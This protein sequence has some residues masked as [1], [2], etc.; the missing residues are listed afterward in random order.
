MILKHYSMKNSTLLKL[1]LAVFGLVI[2]STSSAQTEGS[3]F[4]STGRGVATPF[5]T[6]Y[7]ALGINPSNLDWAPMYEGKSVTF[8]F[9]EVSTSLY[10]EAL[11]KEDLR[12][13][14]TQADFNEL[15]PEEQQQ[16]VL[17]FANSALA[18]DLDVMAT[19]L[20]VR[21]NKLGGFG[22]SV[23]ERVDFFSIM[24][25][26]VAELGILG[27]ESDY[28]DFLV[29]A[30]GDTIPN[31]GSHDLSQED[32]EEGI[33]LL[34]NAQSISDLL[35][36]THMSLSWMREFNFGYG[37]RVW[38]NDNMALYGGIGAKVL[39]GSAFLQIDAEDG[40]AAAFSAMSPYFN[41]D[42]GAEAVSNPSA[43]PESNSLKPVG[44][45]F[46]IDL[47]AS[48]SIQDQFKIGLAITDIGSITWDGNVYEL[49]DILLTTFENPGVETLSILD[50]VSSLTGSDGV[51]EWTGTASHTSKLPTQIRL[52]AGWH[53]EDKLRVGVDMVLPANDELSNL[54]KAVVAV[55]GDFIPMPWLVLSAGF[56][57]G[58]NY[59]F[60]I[61]AG[62]TFVIGGGTWEAGIASRDIIT[63]FSETQPTVS[64]ST[65]FLR[66]RV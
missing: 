44:L 60:K 6:D 7:H 29:T 42:Y 57:N 64:F 17:D 12:K 23:R 38:S 15:T 34:E 13:N 55:G 9:L 40:E 19:G 56:I 61:P 63:F 37:K 41:I 22:F 2:F 14:L 20:A 16:A 1:K 30:Q 54:D 48:I 27:F 8:G 3:A 21:T 39:V 31:D 62:V 50:Q 45:G 53:I 33:T 59:D 35:D 26:Q 28:F 24:G 10:S 65:G 36:G 49:N 11:A 58:G 52:G 5:A 51:L 43:I 18:F 25:P 66:F 4:S 47:G 46:G 32:I